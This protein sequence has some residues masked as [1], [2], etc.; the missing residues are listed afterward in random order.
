[1]DPVEHAKALKKIEVFEKDMAQLA[2]EKAQLTVEKTKAED[3]QK[4]I[5]V[6]A[7]RQSK[8]IKESK[9]LAETH[10]NTI[11]KLTSE[12]E[13]LATSSTKDA[14]LSKEVTQLKGQLTKL[15]S[16]RESE[17]TQLEGANTINDKLRER[18]RQFQKKISE[19]VKKEADL[20]LQLKEAQAEVEKQK[21]ALAEAATSATVGP[22]F[23]DPPVE[24]ALSNAPRASTTVSTPS[25][26]EVDLSGKGAD[27]KADTAVK[28]PA[29]E[30]PAESVP[31]AMEAKKQVPKVPAG[32]FK[33]GPSDPAGDAERAQTP[34][35]SEPPKPVESS[36]PQ[37]A[38]APAKKPVETS[39]PPVAAAVAKKRPASTEEAGPEK[40]KTVISVE[41]EDAPADAAAADIGKEQAVADENVG[42]NS[43]AQKPAIGRRMSGEK[44]ELSFKEKLLERK[45]KLA[46]AMERIKKA[47][48][49]KRSKMEEQAKAE[50]VEGG[51]DVSEQIAEVVPVVATAAT[52]KGS[53]EPPVGKGEDDITANESGAVME[54]DG[55]GEGTD[56][57]EGLGLSGDFSEQESDV[58]SFTPPPPASSAALFG[59]SSNVNPFGVTSFGQAGGTSV[60]G[61]SS[62]FGTG[63]AT[64]FGAVPLGGGAGFGVAPSG[65]GGDSF[66]L[67][68]PF[69]G[70][71]ALLN[72]IPPG[73]S[74]APPQFSFGS[75]SS[76]TL[77]MPAQKPPANALF[78]AFTT[79]QRQY[80][81]G[82]V[83]A[84][85]LF[86]PTTSN[87]KPDEEG[88]MNDDD[89]GEVE[90]GVM[91]EDP[92]GGM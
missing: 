74:T 67:A 56:I 5:R 45:R 25:S 13:A 6:I 79:S 22:S 65:F 64:T 46:E 34:A 23:T 49:T 89:D 85:P 59:S 41:K 91:E 50:D 30:T 58:A 57:V 55:G 18:L 54:D 40:K 51:A 61:M 8:E 2:T 33:F 62:G 15:Q 7:V 10:K 17:K 86:G 72:M 87:D 29:P 52:E 35:A 80:S 48:F 75:S 90:E 28:P 27:D 39:V 31:K 19:S 84:I 26:I 44:K 1:V 82:G 60:F 83:V 53:E 68:S 42:E 81:S 32:G 11:A 16:E 76:I 12:K 88:K 21:K 36:F 24:V 14:S 20:A 78:S 66:T 38:P 71:G 43:E 77:P 92:E 47:E 63:S 69:G 4:R 9:A 37:A 73:S 3:E 70:G